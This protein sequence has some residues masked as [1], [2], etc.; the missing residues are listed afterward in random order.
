MKQEIILNKAAYG[1]ESV[2]GSEGDRISGYSF[3][4]LNNNKE[5]YITSR[6]TARPILEAV[7]DE[8]YKSWKNKAII[9]KKAIFIWEKNMWRIEDYL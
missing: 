3:Y 8:Q 2:K 6:I 9:A 4:E 1:I 7:T 5:H